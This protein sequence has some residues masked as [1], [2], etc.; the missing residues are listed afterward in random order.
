MQHKRIVFLAIT[1]PALII[2]ALYL[3]GYAVISTAPFFGETP[4]TQQ[5][6]LANF[7]VIGGIV[8]LCLIYE[9][10]RLSRKIDR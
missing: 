8:S 7:Y 2:L 10:I 5:E 4:S 1:V 9:A 6:R 3:F